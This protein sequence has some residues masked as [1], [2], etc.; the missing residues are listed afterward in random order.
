MNINISSYPRSTSYV[1]LGAGTN[2]Y[3]LDSNE[4]ILK[5]M[6]KKRIYNAKEGG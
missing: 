6:E 5:E 3:L 1:L 4:L 2:I